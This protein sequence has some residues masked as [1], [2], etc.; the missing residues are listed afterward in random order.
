MWRDEHTGL[1]HTHYRLY[2]PQ[3]VRWLTP[4]PAG[5][6][7]GQNL[8]RFYA[9]PNGVDPLG[10][11][12]EDTV[13][14]AVTS[15]LA[16]KGEVLSRLARIKAGDDEALTAE[17]IAKTQSM[18]KSY[19]VQRNL[20][21]SQIK[22]YMENSSY[23]SGSSY[24]WY[25]AAESKLG[26]IAEV[27]QISAKGELA[28]V[29]SMSNL[30]SSNLE[31]IGTL[32]TVAQYSGYA[33]NAILIGTGIG[34]LG[35]VATRIGYIAFKTGGRI[36]V[37][38]ALK[39][40]G[41][42]AAKT[43]GGIAAYMAV[44]AGAQALATDEAKPY[45]SSQL[46]ILGSL[47]GLKYIQSAFTQEINLIKYAK[48]IKGFALAY[49]NMVTG[50]PMGVSVA[51][52]TKTGKIYYGESGNISSNINKSLQDVMPNPSL[53]AHWAVANC[54]EF[55]AANNALNAG[56][57]MKNLF[58]YTIIRKNKAPFCRCKNCQIT[59]KDAIIFSDN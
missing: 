50:K 1:Y 35:L 14:H 45:V 10:L 46:L 38:Y 27:G 37:N 18:Y 52:D 34:G 29:K 6:R 36:G 24:D 3:H 33:G 59:V 16:T 26:E 32:R 25:Q 49:A 12:D 15:A 8:Y 4:D 56:A 20:A 19:L 40:G 17:Y 51:I 53:E 41:L 30:I 21:N 54:A 55:N 2:D 44:D 48:N 39:E 13:R 42:F 47:I 7:D 28:H 22:A 31:T 58:I 43:V 11:M 5:Y 57:K 9:G 23:F